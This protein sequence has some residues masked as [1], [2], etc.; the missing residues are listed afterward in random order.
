VL[1]KIKSVI[2]KTLSKL[3]VT[4]FLNSSIA[5][6]SLVKNSEIDELRYFA[7]SFAA[8]HFLS[9]SDLLGN[10]PVKQVAESVPSK[11]IEVCKLRSLMIGWAHQTN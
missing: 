4:V 8:L 1:T 5:D 2:S 9:E 6:L 7:K 3:G 11:S 10:S